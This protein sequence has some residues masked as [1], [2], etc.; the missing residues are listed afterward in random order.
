MLSSTSSS[1]KV[2]IFYTHKG[3]VKFQLQIIHLN[4]TC[5]FFQYTAK[6]VSDFPVPV[7]D[8]P[9]GDEKIAVFYSV[10]STCII[11]KTF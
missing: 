3:N 8:I 4:F 1:N 11:Y 2:L 7:S 6:K 9:A 10:L 5:F